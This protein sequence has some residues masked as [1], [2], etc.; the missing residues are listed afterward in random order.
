MPYVRCRGC[1]LRFYTAAAWSTRGDCPLCGTPARAPRRPRGLDDE[2]CSALYDARAGELL[3][4]LA[5][6]TS[7][8]HTAVQ[9]W[10]ET[11]AHA[12]S[13]RDRFRGDTVDHAALWL[14]AIAYRQLAR[15]RARGH[16]EPVNLRRLALQAPDGEPGATVVDT[17][18]AQLIA[19]RLLNE[20][21]DRTAIPPA[22]TSVAQGM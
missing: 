14:E 2:M 12:L 8:E 20:A 18:R 3:A 21:A 1:A 6:R 19:R 17:F 4:F 16:V 7:D 9:L 11:L 15:Y 10:A 5:R 22:L 13:I